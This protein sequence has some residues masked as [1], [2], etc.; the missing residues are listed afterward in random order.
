M[1]AMGTARSVQ[2]GIGRGRR[3]DLL[4]RSSSGGYKP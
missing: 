3:Y 1:L 4:V 2:L